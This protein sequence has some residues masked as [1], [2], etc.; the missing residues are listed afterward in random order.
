MASNTDLVR[1][2]TYFFSG[3]ANA[4]QALALLQYKGIVD[5]FYTIIG[6]A[7]NYASVFFCWIIF[8][9]R[10]YIPKYCSL[11]VGLTA[12]AVY[13]F[14]ATWD[15]WMPI[16]QGA[17]MSDN[18]AMGFVKITLYTNIIGLISCMLGLAIGKQIQKK[19]R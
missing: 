5:T 1:A 14:T 6:N 18:F 2:A 8:K 16:A 7:Y 10:E 3:A 4:E 12:S 15:F 13:Y 11:W 19:E 9:K 17:N